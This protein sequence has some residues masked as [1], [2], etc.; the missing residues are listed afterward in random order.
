MNRGSNNKLLL[1]SLTSFDT[2][3]EPLLNLSIEPIVKQ[4]GILHVKCNLYTS[5]SILQKISI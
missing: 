5:T 1:I 3:L 2:G 4:Q